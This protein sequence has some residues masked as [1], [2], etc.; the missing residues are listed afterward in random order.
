MSPAE[1]MLGPRPTR[2]SRRLGVTPGLGKAPLPA[3]PSSAA[4]SG[5]ARPSAERGRC[6]RPPR[7]LREQRIHLKSPARGMPPS[8]RCTRTLNLSSLA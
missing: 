8:R 1:R 3:R 2:A 7:K 5:S 6:Q 4:S